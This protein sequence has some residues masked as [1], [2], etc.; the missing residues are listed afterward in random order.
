MRATVCELPDPGPEL[1]EAW[2]DLAG[3][4]RARASDL[5]LLPEMPFYR[6]LPVDPRPEPD[7]WEAAVEAHRRWIDR[8]GELGAGTVAATRPVIR[9][10]RRLNEA[11][12][13]TAGGEVRSAHAKRY[14]PDEEGFREATWYDR[15]PGRFEPVELDG[16]R[17]GFLVCTELWFPERA[18]AY[19]RQGIHLLLAPRATPAYSREKWLAGGRTATVIAGAFGLSSNHSGPGPSGAFDWAGGGWVVDPDGEVLGVTSA[20]EPFLT[21]EI[22]PAVAEAA[23]STYPRYV[24]E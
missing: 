14:L 6:W 9:G 24:T 3:H 7:A 2:D 18:R 12:L 5:V 13:W 1:E 17:A 16:A 22:D 15:G 23:K 11:F 8:L 19:G 4:V 20:E 10:G 21:V